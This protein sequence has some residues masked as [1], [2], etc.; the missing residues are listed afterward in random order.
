MT[1]VLIRLCMVRALRVLDLKYLP[2][3]RKSCQAGIRLTIY[4]SQRGFWMRLRQGRL[5][6]GDD[7]GIGVT[8]SSRSA[9][10]VN[11]L[12]ADS[13]P[14]RL[15]FNSS[16][17]NHVFFSSFK[18]MSKYFVDS[19]LFFQHFCKFVNCACLCVRVAT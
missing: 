7:G 4:I 1:L 11:F 15:L 13:Q 6:P 9:R 14:L 12:H 5:K 8:Q 18:S 2:I 16:I 3:V 10:S 17:K 19:H